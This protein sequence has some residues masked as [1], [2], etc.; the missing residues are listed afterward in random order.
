MPYS[1]EYLAFLKKLDQ[2][3]NRTIYAKVIAL[4]LQEQPLQQVEGRVTAGSINIDGASAVRRTCSLT[5]V[6]QN[7][8]YRNYYW[9]MNTKFKLEIGVE[10]KIDNKY[11]PIVWFKQGI[12]LITSLNVSHSTNNFTMSIQGKDKMC[13]LN[14]EVGGSIN[15]PTDFGT[16][17]EDE[18]IINSEGKE[19]IITNIIKLPIKDIIRNAVHTYAGEPYQN[20]IIN[21]LDAYGLELLEYRYDIP[22]YAYKATAL[23]DNIYQNITLNGDMMVTSPKGTGKLSSTMHEPYFDKLVDALTES[24]SYDFTISGEAGTWNFAKLE[25][26]NAA[27]YRETELTYAGDLIANVGETIT[28]VLDKIKNML[29]EF[30]YFY[31]LDGR[32]VFQKKQALVNTLWA[33]S[34]G[35]D[36]EN[37]Y[38]EG[39]AASSAQIYEF[40][41]HNLITA[42]NN[43]PNLLN[44]KNDYSI[45]GERTTISGAKV[46]V[47]LRYAIDTKPQRY[48]SPYPND[49][50]GK[51]YGTDWRELIYIMA[52]DYF[53]HNQDDNFEYEIA[54]ANPIDYPTGITGYEQYYTDLQGFWRQLYNPSPKD[55]EVDLYYT[56]PS[57]DHLYWRK[58]V[59]EHPEA[60]NFW[61][62]FLDFEGELSQFN[63]KNV[64]ART[65]PVNDS[66][67]KSIYFRETPDLIFVNNMNEIKGDPNPA[68]RYLQVPDD[69]MFSISAQGKSA[70]DR[71][72]ELIYQHSYCI[73]TANITA[74]PVYYLQPNTRIHIYD[75]DTHLEGD[76]II[77]RMTIPLTYNGTMSITATKAAETLL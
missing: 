70:K 39:L 11:P 20:I 31:D 29:G 21:N 50:V 4:N 45:W 19:E 15:T 75:K 17:E 40:N 8:D 1:T 27:G 52:L 6:A 55:D 18:K 28:S 41:N 63:V 49:H 61:F 67:I 76:Y 30:E 58:D 34:S 57:D 53:K 44:M 54:Q 2:Q 16:I 24:I 37:A 35:K 74:I 33:P 7:F 43:T 68:Y 48:T 77:S 72:D 46:A 12:F 36:N 51:R 42:F 3:H 5:L 64:G 62:D 38:F 32:F 71:L 10:N 60:L 69:T 47:H 56:H 59:Y 23:P 73:E 9:G 22:M 66:N 65:K 13:Q 25:Y 14:G 26:G